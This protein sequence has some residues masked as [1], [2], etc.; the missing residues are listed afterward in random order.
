MTTLN[1]LQGSIRNILASCAYGIAE[2]TIQLEKKRVTDREYRMVE[3]E[4][5]FAK[6][7]SDRVRFL[8]VLSILTQKVMQHRKKNMTSLPFVAEEDCLMNIVLD[9]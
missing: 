9:N 3:K 2:K 4:N 8:L 1:W 5:S 7:L 6:S